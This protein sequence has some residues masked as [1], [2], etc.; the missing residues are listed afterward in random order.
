MNIK[1]ISIWKQLIEMIFSDV[2]TLVLNIKL[3]GIFYQLTCADETIEEKQKYHFPIIM[4][5]VC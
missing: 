4:E 5:K 2:K 3:Q 1:C